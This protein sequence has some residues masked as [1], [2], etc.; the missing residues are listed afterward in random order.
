MKTEIAILVSAAVVAV[1]ALRLRYG[2]AV[3]G[4]SV[5]RADLRDRWRGLV[6]EEASPIVGAD[7]LTAETLGVETLGGVFTPLIEKGA[8]VPCSRSE[9][10]STAT[11][12]QSDIS[13]ALFRGREKI[14]SRNHALGRFKI[15]GIPAAPRGVPTVKVTFAI[16]GRQILLSARDERS[17]AEYRV[18]PEADPAIPQDAQSH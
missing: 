1:L 10:C 13:V 6:V 15:V 18:L 4:T 16:S 2:N 12:G 8:K 3:A 17:H 9:T 5:A 11:D 7:G 14:A